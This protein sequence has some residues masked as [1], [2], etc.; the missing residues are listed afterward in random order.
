MR[1]SYRYYAHCPS[2]T[3]IISRQQTTATV[4]LPPYK[5]SYSNLEINYFGYRKIQLALLFSIGLFI[6]VL[7]IV[8]LQQVFTGGGSHI[9]RTVWGS[10]EVLASAIVANLPPI[11]G[12]YHLQRKSKTPAPWSAGIT[13]TTK[14]ELSSFKAKG[15]I[16]TSVTSGINSEPIRNSG[17][18]N[19]GSVEYLSKQGVKITDV[20]HG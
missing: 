8:R 3:D 17:S 1:H 5:K 7:T 14:L 13:K 2:I 11:V 12:A 15:D 10:A 18:D 6:V 4:R 20:E 16:H 19:V 9:I